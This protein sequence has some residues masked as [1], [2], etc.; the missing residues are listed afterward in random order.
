M[1]SKRNGRYLIVAIG[2]AVFWVSAGWWAM[3]ARPT[4]AQTG[5]NGVSEPANG[6]IIGGI[7]IVSGTAAHPEFLRY[8]LAFFQDFNP[9][10]GWI[11][12]AEGDQPVINNTL[13]VW[14]TT[15]GRNVNAPVFPDGRYQLRL[16]VVRADFNYD[17][18]FTR[19]LTISNDEPTPTPT[20]TATLTITVAPTILPDRTPAAPALGPLP[21]LTPFPT[22]SPPAPPLQEAVGRED[23][24]TSDD[25]DQP[26]GLLP[27][28][29]TIEVERFSRAFWT[30]V[31]LTFYLFVALGGYLLLRTIWRS[32]F[33]LM[34]LL[35]RS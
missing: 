34:R 15:V 7:V 31:K 16:R 26:R 14:D 12:F 1:G 19:E 35:N 6:D 5:A 24:Q 22:P 20:I 3:T 27:Q 28:L 18:Y 32:R 4:A 33:R 29:M 10:A 30:G 13:A 9:G 8:E 23:R 11:V 2:I 25:P 21:S 17:E